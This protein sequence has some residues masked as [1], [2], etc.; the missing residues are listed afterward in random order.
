MHGCSKRKRTFLLHKLFAKKIINTF[1]QIDQVQ[2]Q[3]QIEYM[4][5]GIFFY[6]DEH[7]F[8][9][10]RINDEIHKN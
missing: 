8:V 3:Y 5:I 4:F 10:I 1:L 2:N 9:V 7:L 6:F